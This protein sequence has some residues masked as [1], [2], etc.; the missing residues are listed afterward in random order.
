MEAFLG[1][2]PPV[3]EARPDEGERVREALQRHG[4]GGVRAEVAG[5]D[6][7]YGGSGAAA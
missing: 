7:D 3:V 1:R 2:L 5:F 6:F 4:G